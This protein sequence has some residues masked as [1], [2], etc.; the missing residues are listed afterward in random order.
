MAKRIEN[1][2]TAIRKICVDCEDPFLTTSDSKDV[3]D[4]CYMTR[5]TKAYA[6]RRKQKLKPKNKKD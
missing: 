5:K 6:Q 4:V 2:K 3:C 1:F